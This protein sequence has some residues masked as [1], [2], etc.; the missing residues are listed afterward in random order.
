M[1]AK[2]SPKKQPKRDRLVVD[3]LLGKP[4]GQCTLA[5]CRRLEVF[6]DAA[7]KY[8]ATYL[9]DPSATVTRL[10]A[11]EAGKRRVWPRDDSKAA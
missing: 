6:F 10:A 1:T 2:R 3:T 11:G 8:L 9:R 7:L 5:E 4:L